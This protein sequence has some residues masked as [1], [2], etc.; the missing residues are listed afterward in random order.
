VSEAQGDRASLG[1]K[2]DAV[3]ADLGHRHSGHQEVPDPEQLLVSGPPVR[4]DRPRARRGDRDAAELPFVSDRRRRASGD[5]ARWHLP[6]GR[7]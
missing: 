3:L 5:A 2:D 6:G 1:A 4:K 7:P